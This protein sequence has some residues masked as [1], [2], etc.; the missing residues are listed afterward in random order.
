MSSKRNHKIRS[1]KTYKERIRLARM[2]LS[3]S[4]PFEVR[5]TMMQSRRAK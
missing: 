1:R 3:G 2:N 4:L 5:Q